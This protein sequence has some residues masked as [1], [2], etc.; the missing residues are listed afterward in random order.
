[1]NNYT[2]SKSYG[3]STQTV[4]IKNSRVNMRFL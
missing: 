3:T 4:N 1:M 2:F